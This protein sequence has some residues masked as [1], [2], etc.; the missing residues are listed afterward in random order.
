[1]ST[2]TLKDQKIGC[3]RTGEQVGNR[4]YLIPCSPPYRGEQGTTQAGTDHKTT[5]RQDSFVLS[6]VRLIRGRCS[7]RSAG[8]LYLREGE[9]MKNA[10]LAA[11]GFM[12]SR[13]DTARLKRALKRGPRL[14]RKGRAEYLRWLIKQSRKRRNDSDREDPPCF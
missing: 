4:L 3:S 13:D 11:Q 9:P 1:V 5:R 10:D 12:S 14:T 2:K 6:G 7:K 8:L